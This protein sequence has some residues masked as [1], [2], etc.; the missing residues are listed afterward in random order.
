MKILVRAFAVFREILG[1]RIV[2]NIPERSTLAGLL[3]ELGARSPETKATLFD[4]EG[5][6]KRHVI[7]MVNKKRVN[8][9]DIRALVLNEEDEVAIYPPVAGG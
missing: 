5:V 3:E 8:R 9:A 2:M 4:E 6:L 7:I 1:E